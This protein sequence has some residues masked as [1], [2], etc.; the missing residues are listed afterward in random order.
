MHLATASDRYPRSSC[1][2]EG[3][4]EE[5]ERHEQGRGPEPLMIA[6]VTTLGPGVGALV[7]LLSPLPVRDSGSPRACPGAVVAVVHGVRTGA[8]S[9]PYRGS[10]APVVDRGRRS[11]RS[12]KHGHRGE[13]LA[14]LL[15]PTLLVVPEVGPAHWGGLRVALSLNWPRRQR[16]VS[17]LLTSKRPLYPWWGSP[18]SSPIT[19]CSRR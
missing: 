17:E 6:R 14:I 2:K 12:E 1:M 9:G 16:E 7:H 10:R 18:L 19:P 13:I 15:L 11:P 3:R 5:R 8:V 4:A